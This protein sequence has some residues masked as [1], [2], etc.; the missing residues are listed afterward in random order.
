VR[1]DRDRL[2]AAVDAG[3]RLEREP[4]LGA[5]LGPLRTGPRSE[6]HRDDCDGANA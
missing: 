1:V 4:A 5:R 3:R 6:E 2:R